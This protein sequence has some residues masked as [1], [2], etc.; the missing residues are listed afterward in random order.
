MTVENDPFDKLKDVVKF[1]IKAGDPVDAFMGA[2]KSAITEAIADGHMFIDYLQ[3]RHEME[4][5]NFIEYDEN[6]WDDILVRAMGK[7]VEEYMDSAFGS[8]N[9]SLC[10]K[11]GLE[12]KKI[13]LGPEAEKAIYKALGGD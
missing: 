5:Q 1:Y 8:E 13:E 3:W 2:V 11:L 4:D 12:P 10:K 7:N 9:D 6:E